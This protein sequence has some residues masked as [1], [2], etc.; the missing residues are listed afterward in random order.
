MR[1]R[2]ATNDSPRNT[3]KNGRTSPF[4]TARLEDQFLPRSREGHE[5]PKRNGIVKCKKTNAV[6]L[7][8]FPVSASLRLCVS[9]FFCIHACLDLNL[10]PGG[11]FL[12]WPDF[13][14]AYSL[15]TLFQA[16]RA[17]GPVVPADVGG[18]H[19]TTL[20]QASPASAFNCMRVVRRPVN[21]SFY[22]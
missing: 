11:V 15:A 7:C 16:L 18:G 5:V 6:P 9:I 2:V 22:I 14:A 3:L 13:S 19:S 21:S 10:L 20:G 12:F 4:R 1:A 17:A 8:N